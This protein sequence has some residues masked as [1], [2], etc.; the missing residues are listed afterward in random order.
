M[1]LKKGYN[2]PIGMNSTENFG[3]ESYIFI[4]LEI[5]K[6]VVYRCMCTI[7]KY[8][9]VCVHAHAR[10]VYVQY[11]YTLEA[12]ISTSDNSHTLYW[13]RLSNPKPQEIHF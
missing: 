13:M 12:H 5:N 9:C 6:Y 3:C 11:M 10:I 2:C 7:Y 4:V 1:S 8:A